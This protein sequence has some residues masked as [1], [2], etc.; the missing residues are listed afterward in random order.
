MAWGK[1]SATR[2]PAAIYSPS[3]PQPDF[4]SRGWTKVGLA[5]VSNSRCGK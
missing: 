5:K 1:R 2:D 3:L 4:W